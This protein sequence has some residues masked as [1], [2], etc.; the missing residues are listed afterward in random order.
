VLLKGSVSGIDQGR[1]VL[2]SLYALLEEGRPIDISNVD[3]IIRMIESE[4]SQLTLPTL[5]KKGKVR[6]A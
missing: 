4:D 5:E 2:E 6:M 3:S 1:R